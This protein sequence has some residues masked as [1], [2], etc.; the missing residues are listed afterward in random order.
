MHVVDC[1]RPASPSRTTAGTDGLDLKLPRRSS[2]LGVG[3]CRQPASPSGT[4]V[5]TDDLDLKS[6]RRSSARR[7]LLWA[8]ITIE[9][10]SG[11]RQFRP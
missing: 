10:N 2:A 3:G 8:D 1:R 9:D 5:R 4:T 6:P 11:D 7:R